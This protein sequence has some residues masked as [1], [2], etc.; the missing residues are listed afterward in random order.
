MS[1]T[2][3]SV[4]QR[5]RGPVLG[6]CVDL[7]VVGGILAIS[8]RGAQC[9]IQEGDKLKRGG[10]TDR[11][12]RAAISSYMWEGWTLP[13]YRGGLNEPLFAVNS[14]ENRVLVHCDRTYESRVQN[15]R[16]GGRPPKRPT[17]D[18]SGGSVW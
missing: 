16:R 13:Y 18:V 7:I 2:G 11:Q 6:V 3:S 14:F 12:A 8:K 10:V 15:G 5:Q 1:K 4:F 9:V 17:W